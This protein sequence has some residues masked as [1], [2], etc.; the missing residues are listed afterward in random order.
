MTLLQRSK[1]MRP[2][3]F[4]LALIGMLI[5]PVWAQ[6]SAE[7]PMTPESQLIA[8]SFESDAASW[9]RNI[10]R[11]DSGRSVARDGLS[12]STESNPGLGMN[13]P[14]SESSSLRFGAQTQNLDVDNLRTLDVDTWH[15]GYR[16]TWD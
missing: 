4:A 7:E 1:T 13:I 3:L 14:L 2:R 10:Y 8:D 16:F 11:P 12:F 15:L 5:G 6:S 9:V